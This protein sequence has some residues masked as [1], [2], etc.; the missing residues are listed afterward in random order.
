MLVGPEPE[1]CRVWS[2]G[3]WTRPGQGT[4]R[5]RVRAGM[6]QWRD[7]AEAR[8]WETWWLRHGRAV[9]PNGNGQSGSIA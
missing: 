2:W 5:R 8:W 3:D 6:G 7:L 1:M 9:G 4:V